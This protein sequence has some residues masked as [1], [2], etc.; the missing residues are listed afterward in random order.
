M[1]IIEF[2]DGETYPDLGCN[3][4][5][6][7]NEELLE[8]EALSPL[9]EL[10][11]GASTGHTEEWQLF[12]GVVAPPAK[13]DEA[14]ADLDRAVAAPRRSGRLAGDARLNSSTLPLPKCRATTTF[15]RSC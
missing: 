2:R 13:D 3:F 1:K 11:P 8:V 14:I 5:T 7:A 15:E 9:V 4:E 6:F 10:A 12:S